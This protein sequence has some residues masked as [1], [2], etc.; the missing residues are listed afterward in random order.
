MN[1]KDLR[2]LADMCGLVQETGKDGFVWDPERFP[3][4]ALRLVPALGQTLSLDWRE[5]DNKWYALIQAD[6]GWFSATADVAPAAITTAVLRALKK[7]PKK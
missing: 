1:K 7:R 2:R 4:Q 3:H 6:W 5:T